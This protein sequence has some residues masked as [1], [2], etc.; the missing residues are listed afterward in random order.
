MINQDNDTIYAKQQNLDNSETKKSAIM[1]EMT[2]KLLASAGVGLV[3]GAGATFA[4]DHLT[5]TDVTPEP[6]D[7]D[8]VEEQ[9]QENAAE[10]TVEERLAVLEEKERIREQQEQARLHEANHHVE[11]KPA[12]K[13]QPESEPEPVS[14]P[15]PTPVGDSSFFNEHK[16][17]ISSSE[18]YTFEGGETV[19]VYDGRVDGHMA[20]F[21]DDGEGRI[22]AAIIDGNDNGARDD[23][24]LF[25]LRPYNISAQQMI[26]H[27]VSEPQHSVEVVEVVRGVET[28][29]GTVDV[30]TVAEDGE[31]K[32]YVDENQNGEVDAIICDRNHNGVLDAGEADDVSEYH[33]SMPTEDDIKGDVATIVDDDS[34][35]YVNN[36]DITVYEV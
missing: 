17:E 22:V 19:N 28:E 7:T 23:D 29:Y 1:D 30:A 26:D 16:V 15:E 20:R 32:L 8:K 33:I 3:A 31:I 18:R 9:N 14:Q 2:A 6:E 13:P 27:H 21:M 5:S 36:G 11:P 4:A 24:E 25:D 34:G 12:P 10:P 35:D